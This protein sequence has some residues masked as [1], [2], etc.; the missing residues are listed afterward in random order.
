MSEESKKKVRYCITC[1]N[2]RRLYKRFVPIST[3][4]GMSVVWCLVCNIVLCRFDMSDKEYD[5]GRV[6]N[7]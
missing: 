7:E 5:E 4:D 1:P 6:N 2:C 3:N